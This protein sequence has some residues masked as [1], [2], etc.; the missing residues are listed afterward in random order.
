MELQAQIDSI[1]QGQTLKLGPGEHRGPIVI[2][3][4]ITIE[5][6]GA[7]TIWAAEGPVV[8]IRTDGVQMNKLNVEITSKD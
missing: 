5:G 7:V 4:P 2:Q 8:S 1:Q 6:Q 3:R